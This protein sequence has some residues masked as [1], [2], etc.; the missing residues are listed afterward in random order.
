MEYNKPICKIVNIAQMEVVCGSD[1][2][3]IKPLD[4]IEYEEDDIWA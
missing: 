3:R 1:K 2:G 4:T